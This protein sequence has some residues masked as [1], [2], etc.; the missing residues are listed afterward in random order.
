MNSKRR[1]DKTNQDDGTLNTRTSKSAGAAF[2]DNL[3]RMRHAGVPLQKHTFPEG[4]VK[5]EACRALLTG[6]WLETILIW[7]AL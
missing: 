2:L 1:P 7:Y 6:S 3:S 5:P 4:V